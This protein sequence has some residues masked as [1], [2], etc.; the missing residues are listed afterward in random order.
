MTAEAAPSSGAA[1]RLNFS[2]TLRTAVGSGRGNRAP[3]RRLGA[4]HGRTIPMQDFDIT[5][6]AKRQKTV[7]AK[8]AAT[9]AGPLPDALN[10]LN[11]QAPPQFVADVRALLTDLAVDAYHYQGQRAFELPRKA[12]AI[13]EGGHA[14][15]AQLTGR[16][17]RSVRVRPSF[18]PDGTIAWGG[19]T[20]TDHALHFSPETSFEEYR[21]ERLNTLAGVVAEMLF[22]KGFRFGSSLDEIVMTRVLAGGIAS[23]NGR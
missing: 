4:E 19:T 2:E 8:I 20:D 15:I 5:P 11:T 6:D 1:R 7:E 17:V 14:V 21:A 9:F 13:H 12:A 22:Q 23:K 3:A 18:H 16:K 10:C